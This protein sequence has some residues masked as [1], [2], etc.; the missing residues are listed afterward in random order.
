MFI[1][2][3]FVIKMKFNVTVCVFML[4]IFA[5]I[6]CPNKSVTVVLKTF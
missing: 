2:C 6:F 5:L 4:I 3:I 1:F